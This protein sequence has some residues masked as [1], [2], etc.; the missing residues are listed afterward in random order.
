MFFQDIDS[1]TNSDDSYI[2]GPASMYATL[3]D[4]HGLVH[5]FAFCWTLADQEMI[6]RGMLHN[7]EFQLLA[8]KHVLILQSYAVSLSKTTE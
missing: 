3:S 7:P 8:L 2:N 6:I 1:H 4:S 5:C